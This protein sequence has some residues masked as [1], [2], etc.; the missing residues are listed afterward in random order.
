MTED[1]AGRWPALVPA[2]NAD[3]TVAALQVSHAAPVFEV[4]AACTD[5]GVRQT[6][7]GTVPEIGIAAEVWKQAHQCA[8]RLGE[9][10]S[11]AVTNGDRSDCQ[12]SA[13]AP[14]QQ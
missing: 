7:W 3:A 1:A 11:A 10:G 6:F 4:V 9:S 14:G 12:A 2:G 5:C 8:A 13:G